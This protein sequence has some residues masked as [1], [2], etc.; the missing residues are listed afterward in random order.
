MRFMIIIFLSVTVFATP[1][2]ASAG[3]LTPPGAP[4]DPSGAVYTLEDLE[5][6]KSE[7]EIRQAGKL[8]VEGK[9]YVMQDGDICHFLFNV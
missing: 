6:L 8:R 5:T 2:T 7:K 4:D 1:L 3:S 9:N